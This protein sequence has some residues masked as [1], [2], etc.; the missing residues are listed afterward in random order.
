MAF[1][2]PVLMTAITCAGTLAL[3]GPAH[4]A[5]SSSTQW[6]V[7]A[8]ALSATATKQFNKD[9]SVIG[10]DI[11]STVKNLASIVA[12]QPDP[13]C[14]AQQTSQPFAQWRDTANYVPVP[15]SGFEQG[16]DSW[17]PGGKVALT[18]ENNPYF[19]S[20][21]AADA[22]SASLPLG[23]SLASASFCGGIEYPT[24]RMM[25]KSVG[26]KSAKASVLIRYTGRDGLVGALPLGTITAGSA[27]A[28]SEITMTA[29]GVPLFTGTKLGVTITSTS[30]TIAI[31]DVYVDPYRRT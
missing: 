21:R 16:F 28:P 12:P 4:A 25:A 23:A 5:T 11:Q 24:I 14:L 27:W 18:A 3:A 13:A 7:L 26:G 6:R 10:S 20:G 15:N 1:P 9:T 31:D 29:S 8:E 22:K 19:I 17:I 2:R 30:G